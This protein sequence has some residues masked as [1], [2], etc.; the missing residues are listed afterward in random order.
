MIYMAREVT[1]APDGVLVDH[2]NRDHTL[3]NRRENLRFCNNSEN[4][5]NC[6]P[7]KRNRSGFKGVYWSKAANK[8]MARITANKVD[9]YLGVFD[10]PADAA[11]AY[12]MRARELFGEFAWTNF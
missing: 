10:D 1:R 5:S 9:F 6:G 3:D 7:R 2:K 4:N 11:K 8:Y 12:D